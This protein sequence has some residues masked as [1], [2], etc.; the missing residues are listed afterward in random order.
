[1]AKESPWDVQL[2]MQLQTKYH[3]LIICSFYTDLISNFNIIDFS[4]AVVF[5]LSKVVDSASK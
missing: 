4:L 3:K 5:Q 2:L 1:M